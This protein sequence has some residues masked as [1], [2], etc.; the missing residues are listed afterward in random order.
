MIIYY[1]HDHRDHNNNLCHNHYL[2][3][4][5][6]TGW[7][8]TIFCAQMG[9]AGRAPTIRHFH[10]HDRQQHFSV[11]IIVTIIILREGTFI[12]RHFK[13]ISEICYIHIYIYTLSYLQYIQIYTIHTIY[14]DIYIPT[15]ST[16]IYKYIQLYTNICKVVLSFCF[17]ACV[18]AKTL[19]FCERIQLMWYTLIDLHPRVLI[20]LLV[21]RKSGEVLKLVV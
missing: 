6:R 20:W 5:R 7:R 16:D 4:S 11:I 15:V 9:V 2:V 14:T 8:R 3:Q 18:T 10:N 1:Q 21:G 12:H 19:S 13:E 17:L